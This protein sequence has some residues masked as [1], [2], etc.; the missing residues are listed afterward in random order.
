MPCNIKGK[1]KDI[2]LFLFVAIWVAPY[3]I[4]KVYPGI[5]KNFLDQL[6]SLISKPLP[7]GIP[8]GNAQYSAP[9]VRSQPETL[10]TMALSRQQP[11]GKEAE[12]E[13]LEEIINRVSAENALDSNL[14]RAI[15]KVE[16]NFDP[17][18]VSVKGAS[19]LMQLMPG[20]AANLGVCNPF[21]PAENISG[22]A[23]YLARQLKE[24]KDIRL[25]LAAYNAGPEAV[26]QYDGIPPYPET[27]NFV[28]L[29]LAYYDQ[30][31]KEDA[32]RNQ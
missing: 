16:S 32:E 1:V 29:V 11:T 7:T 24:F 23:L 9:S 14:V 8:S 2:L 27:Q 3:M 17:E 19:G 12:G 26:M 13:S 5:D 28:R 30:F 18:A 10:I 22:G 15:I 21:N 25:A 31:S 20:T 6:N 4:P